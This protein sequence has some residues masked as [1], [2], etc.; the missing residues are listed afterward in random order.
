MLVLIALACCGYQMLMGVEFEDAM[1]KE[2][3]NTSMVMSYLNRG[4]G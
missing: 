2:S 3:G 4:Q 1:Q